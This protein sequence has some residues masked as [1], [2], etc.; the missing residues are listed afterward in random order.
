MS[1]VARIAAVV[2]LV[3]ASAEAQEPAGTFD[4]LPVLVQP[5]ETLTV[6]N[7]SGERVRGKLSQLSPSSLVL[8]VLGT[9]REFQSTDVNTIEK[10]DS[11]KNGALIGMAV[12]AGIL[13]IGI[14]GSAGSSEADAGLFVGGAVVYAAIGAAI[15]TGIDALVDGRRL[16]YARPTS[17]T[18]RLTF[19]PLLGGAR[20]GVLVSLRVMQ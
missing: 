18:T 7:D 9:Q 12:G 16:I 6:T 17:P 11:L 5:G 20:K 4:Q 8:D 2:I 10:P 1:Q 19:A 15:G 14:A 13:G 3:A